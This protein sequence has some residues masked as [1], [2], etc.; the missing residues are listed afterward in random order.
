LVNVTISILTYNGNDKTIKTISDILSQK[1]S[2]IK[3]KLII[4]DNCSCNNIVNRITEIFPEC[5]IIVNK[6]NSGFSGGNNVA[7][8][9]A[10]KFG[11]DFLF[12]L[13][14]DLQ[15]RPDY[16]QEMVGKAIKLPEA[17]AIGS[18][19]ILKNGTVQAVCGHLS[20]WYTGVVW[21][22]KKSKKYQFNVRETDA[23]QG[24]AF[25]LTRVALE[26]GFMFDENLFLGGEEYDLGYWTKMHGLKTYVLE[27]IE[28]VHD[29]KQNEIITNRWHSDPIQ[30]YY[31]I[32]NNIYVKNKYE[33]NKSINIISIFILII[34]ICTKA[35]IFL[36]KGN[37]DIF[38]YSL[39]GLYDGL[40][41]KM[42][43]I[44]ERWQKK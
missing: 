36:S 5:N 11:S 14:D 38:L 35:S 19:I 6:S 37:K 1:Y 29:T 3:V 32:R 20:S 23:I 41:K 28:V 2:N 27:N 10:K 34:R 42:G 30:Y 9:I 31:A 16:I 44:D 8:K 15:L 18:T 26:K 13:N 22:Q 40:S 21:N 24:A 33:K 12:V 43:M 17:A 4:I 25:M 39:K 7:I